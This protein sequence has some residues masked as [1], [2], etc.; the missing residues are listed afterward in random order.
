MIRR[1]LGFAHNAD[2]ETIA[3]PDRRAACER[4]NLELAR[5]LI[6]HAPAIAGW[7]EVTSRA[8]ELRARGPR[9][10]G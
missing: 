7:A 3:D 8:R 1:T 4:L 5:E 10:P 9:F 6:L 2:F